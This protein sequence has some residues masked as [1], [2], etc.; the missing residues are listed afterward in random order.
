[1]RRVLTATVT[2]TAVMLALLS[3][4]AWANHPVIV[5]G[6]C[7][8]DGTGMSASGI[9]QGMV[10]P[11]TCGDHDGDGRIGD[12]EDNDGDNTFGS[13]G[14]AVESVAHNGRVTIVESGTFPEVVKLNPRERASIVLEAAP[15][16]DAN[17]DA[18]T[19]GEAGGEERGN[20]PGIIVDGCRRCRAIVRNV[21][22]RNWTEG[23]R[24]VGRSHVLLDRVRAEGNLNYGIRA[25]DH[26]RVT[27]TTGNVSATGY[28]KDAAGAGDARPGIGMEFGDHSRA[29]IS[30]TVVTGSARA[31]IRGYRDALRLRDNELFDNNPNLVLRTRRR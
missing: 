6:N 17:I 2:V 22:T 12:A 20:S 13:I 16:V 18:V 15:G 25:K 11:G 3:G 21:T 28:R 24:V 27:M 9:M 31:G 30:E 1:M 4:P 26:A 29:L 19:Q 5:E 7:F 23:V 8:G 10:L 14:A